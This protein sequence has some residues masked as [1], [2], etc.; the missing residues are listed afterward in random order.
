MRTEPKATVY[1]LGLDEEFPNGPPTVTIEHRGLKFLLRF[2]DTSGDG[3]PIRLELL[4]DTE[5]LEPRVLRQFAPRAELYLGLARAAMKLFGPE[6]TPESR[7]ADLR[8]A[9]EALRQVGGPGRG[10][11]DEFYRV[12]AQHYN[13]LV[14]EGEPHPVKALGEIHQVTISTAS[15]WITEAK[16][17]R[18]I[19]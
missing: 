4:P 8:G 2:A 17:R 6:G 13:T 18:L 10:L 15:R 3:L 1:P 12:I 14:A 7:R 16:R 11:S 19:K 9:T 5:T